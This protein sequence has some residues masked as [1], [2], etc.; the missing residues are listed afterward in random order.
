M[1]QPTPR[2]G[3]ETC[4][5]SN[6]SMILWKQPTPRK[7]TET[8]TSSKAI[9]IMVETTHTPQGDG[10]NAQSCFRPAVLETTHT[11]QGDGNFLAA[12]RLSVSNRNNPH[13]ARGRKHYPLPLYGILI[14]KQ[15]TPRKGTETPYIVAHRLLI[16]K[17]P[18]PRKGT[19]TPDSPWRRQRPDGNNPRPARGR[20]LPVF[21]PLFA[22]FFE[23][24]HTPQGGGNQSKLPKPQSLSETTHTPQG[25]GNIHSRLQA[26]PR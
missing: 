22:P 9:L 8:T 25:D 18:T 1:K 13:P 6:T 14:T 15:P 17:Q 11:P 24:T 2:K 21:T 5:N 4:H 7:G 10:N 23:T 19:E 16:P 26:V 3:T 20:K 12:F